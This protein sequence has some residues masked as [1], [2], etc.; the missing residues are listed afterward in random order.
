MSS[1]NR[2]LPLR[3]WLIEPPPK[4]FS[5]KINS[6]RIQ[7]KKATHLN[8]FLLNDTLQQLSSWPG[9]APLVRQHS[10]TR[11]RTPQSIEFT[12]CVGLQCQTFATTPCSSDS[13]FSTSF[14]HT[15][16]ASRISPQSVRLAQRLETNPHRY[17]PFSTNQVLTFSSLIQ[18]SVLAHTA[19][20]GVV[21]RRLYYMFTDY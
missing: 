20:G 7:W 14:D 4:F 18:M 10:S 11:G 3:I 19:E 16:F 17:T 6:I 1:R 12:P 5:T 2:C 15:N 13:I 8:V 9:L 21:C